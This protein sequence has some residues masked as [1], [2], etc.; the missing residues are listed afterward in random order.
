MRL[1]E[2]QVSGSGASVRGSGEPVWPGVRA[3]T[4]EC[5]GHSGVPKSPSWGGRGLLPLTATRPGT[6]RRQGRQPELGGCPRPRGP[7]SSWQREQGALGWPRG[8]RGTASVRGCHVRNPSCGPPAWRGFCCPSEEG[9]RPCLP[10][11]LPRPHCRPAAPAPWSLLTRRGAWWV[12]SSPEPRRDSFSHSAP[13]AGAAGRA[14]SVSGPGGPCP[15]L[16][17]C[18]HRIRGSTCLLRCPHPGP[19]S[20]WSWG[21]TSGHGARPQG[22]CLQPPLGSSSGKPPSEFTSSRP[23][24]GSTGPQH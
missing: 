3:S 5:G 12:G 16:P 11:G 20:G 13:T 21:S 19:A 23:A 24:L 7:L 15:R 22:G 2:V 14:W 8:H 1:H 9:V 17:R 10:S 18:P 6:A 4:R